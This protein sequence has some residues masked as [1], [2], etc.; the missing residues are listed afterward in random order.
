MT[1][2]ALPSVLQDLICSIAFD[3]TYLELQEDIAKCALVQES[4]PPSF[5]VAVLFHAK[6]WGYVNTPFKK[7]NAFYPTRRLEWTPVWNGIPLAFC[8]GI[9][10][11][12]IRGLKT[13]KA[14]VLRRLA[15]MLQSDFS[16][17]NS[18]Y[19][20]VFSKLKAEHFSKNARR[21]FVD[22]I[23]LELSEASPLPDDFCF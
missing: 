1:F 17:W 23:L 12:A 8:C 14:I 3:I 4:V 22:Q 7:G 15:K 11:E 2:Q 10:K 20:N 5:L 16:G 13:Y 19:K 6:K 9:N 18:M 21:S